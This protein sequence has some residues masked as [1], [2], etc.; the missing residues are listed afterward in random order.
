MKKLYLIALLLVILPVVCGGCD[1]IT[2]KA[3]DETPSAYIQNWAWGTTADGT[4]TVFDRQTHEPI[5]DITPQ[6]AFMIKMSSSNSKNPVL[7]DVR[8]PEEYATRHALLSINIDFNSSTFQ[9]EISE[10]NKNYTY[11]VYCT[12]GYRSNLARNIMEEL[13]FKSVI[14]VTGGFNAWVAAGIPVE[15]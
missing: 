5:R 7:L 6:D 1:Y 12:S 15:Q 3:L 9:E 11:I 2:G 13:G 8:T 4:A 14:N 10:F